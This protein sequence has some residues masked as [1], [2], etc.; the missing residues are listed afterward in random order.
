[1][2]KQ[3]GHAAKRAATLGTLLTFGSLLLQTAGCS[4]YKQVAPPE[5]APQETPATT[6]ESTGNR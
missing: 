1:M 6:T 5:P 2:L 3:T 4:E